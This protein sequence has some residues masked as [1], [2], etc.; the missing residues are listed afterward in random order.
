MKL[1]TG[2]FVAV[3]ILL[4]ACDPLPLESGVDYEP[5]TTLRNSRTGR[6]VEL[7][8]LETFSS[9]GFAVYVFDDA[10]PRKR[11]DLRPERGPKGGFTP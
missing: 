10:G 4:S 9:H 1:E 5:V 7:A 8:Q 3:T 11:F 2:S 6:Y